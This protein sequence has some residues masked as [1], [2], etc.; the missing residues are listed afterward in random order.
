MAVLAG[1]FVTAFL[2]AT[3]LP[4]S[5]EAAL[6]AALVGSGQPWALLIAAASLGNVLGSL[7]NWMIGRGLAGLREGRLRPKDE[8]RLARAEGWYRRWG[9]WTLLLSW[10]PVI[11]DPLTIAAGLLREPLRVFIP[12][13]AAAKTGRYLAVAAAASGLL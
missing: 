4:F 5:S 10:V 7:T 6:A 11:G 1:L 13:V 9:R 3:I 8:A 2:A 12:L